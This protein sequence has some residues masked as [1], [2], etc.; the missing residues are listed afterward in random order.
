MI[1]FLI[2]QKSIITVLHV[3]VMAI[4]VGSATITDVFFFRFLKNFR[5]SRQESATM[6]VFSGVIWVALILA[7]I[8]GVA[9]YLTD[10]AR[11]NATPKFLVKVVVIGVI[12]LNGLLLNFYISSRLTHVSF[13][14]AE[15]G[16][17]DVF[18]G[19]RRLAF[20]SGAVS[21]TSWYT[22]LAIGATS[23]IPFS[24]GQIGG[25]YAGALALAIIGSQLM[26]RRYAI[27]SKNTGRTL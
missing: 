16:R 5:I 2:A 21:M 25:V 3:L 20:A 26:E 14:T 9:L 7:V 22:A 1:E 27:L 10:P 18:R 24:F 13:P 11:Y 15:D 4:G 19:F 12:V 17:R 8:T 6:K 23:S